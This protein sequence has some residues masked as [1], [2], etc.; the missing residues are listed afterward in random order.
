MPAEPDGVRAAAGRA[1]DADRGRVAGEFQ[2]AP[3]LGD[4]LRS[5]VD[6]AVV[7]AQISLRVELAESLSG[8]GIENLEGLV[9]VG[10]VVR[11]PRLERDQRLPPGLRGLPPTV[12]VVEALPRQRSQQ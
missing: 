2:G 9:V 7:P 12:P 6:R 3:R 8:A 1:V 4:K 5:R 10:P 11:L